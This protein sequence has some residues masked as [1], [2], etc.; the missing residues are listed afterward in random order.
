MRAIIPQMLWTGASLAYWSAFLTPINS[1]FL[2]HEHHK[3][4]EDEVLEK[5]QL[6]LCFFGIGSAC[7]AII[8]GKIIDHTSSKKAIII[9]LIIMVATAIISIY[10]I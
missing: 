5:C 8:M 6:A 3:I 2:H 9:N 7:S 1:K 10:N 4:H